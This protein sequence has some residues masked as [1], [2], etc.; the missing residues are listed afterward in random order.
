MFDQCW[1]TQETRRKFE[2]IVAIEW[3]MQCETLP[4][5]CYICIFTE[6]YAFR[7]RN[8]PQQDH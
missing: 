5:S 7:G 1:P 8:E 2:N 4:I 3:P 6:S